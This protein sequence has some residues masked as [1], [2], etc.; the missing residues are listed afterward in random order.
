MMKRITKV[1]EDQYETEDLKQF[2]FVPML[3]DKAWGG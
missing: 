2:R 1:S 3:E